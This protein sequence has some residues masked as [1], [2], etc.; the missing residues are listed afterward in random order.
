MIVID[1]LAD[2]VLKVLLAEDTED[3]ETLIRI[4]WAPFISKRTRFFADIFHEH[5]MATILL[6]WELGGGLGHLAN[7]GPIAGLLT[8][9]GHRVCAALRHP[10]SANGILRPY[11]H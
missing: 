6:T 9:R 11:W 1:V 4:R 5:D 2:Q 8:D 7:L 10:S 3:S